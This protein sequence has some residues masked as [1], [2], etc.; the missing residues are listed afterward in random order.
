MPIEHALRCC[1]TLCAP[2]FWVGEV[3]GLTWSASANG[4]NALIAY[5]VYRRFIAHLF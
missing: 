4:L 5:T 2:G 1:R 3:W